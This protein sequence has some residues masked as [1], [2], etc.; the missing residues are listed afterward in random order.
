MNYRRFRYVNRYPVGANN[1]E[2]LHCHGEFRAESVEGWAFCPLCGTFMDG[3]ITSRPADVP[4]WLYNWGKKHYPGMDDHDLACLPNCPQL[5][6][7]EP[8]RWLVIER[9]RVGSGPH[10]LW[11][12]DRTEQKI[13]TRLIDALIMRN[14]L[15]K[16]DRARL[17]EW[18]IRRI[19]IDDALRCSYL[20]IDRFAIPSW[21]NLTDVWF[22]G[23]GTA[24]PYETVCWN[25]RTTRDQ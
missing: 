21:M 10:G 19:E 9:K 8:K 12:I 6:F 24:L 18:R 15:A 13:D 5:K 2:C 17:Y 3:S 7:K 1:I 20:F 23:N 16:Y 4:K 25:G 14:R 11:E 22:E